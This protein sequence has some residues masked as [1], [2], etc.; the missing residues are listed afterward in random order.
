MR[1][2]LQL[3]DDLFVDLQRWAER[4]GLTFSE[5]V[6]LALRQSLA[7]PDKSHRRFRQKTVALGLPSFDVSCANAADARLEDEEIAHRARIHG[8]RLRYL[9]EPFRAEA[10]GAKQTVKTCKALQ[11][12]LG[13]LNDLHNLAATVGEALE[14]ASVERAR[15]LREL[16][17]RVDGALETEL[18][19][20]HEPGLLAMLQ[21]I[22]RD[23]VSMF[24]SLVNDWLAPGGRLDEL[25]GQIRSLGAH[26]RGREGVEIERKYLLFGL[27]PRCEE[28]APLT[29]EQGYLPGERLVE[30]VRRITDGGR[31]TTL[32]TVKLGAGVQRIEV[33]EECS[34][35]LFDALYAL[36]EG[37]RVRKHRF[38]VP[39]GSLL[40]EID[41]FLDRELFLAEVELPTADTEVSVPEWLLPYLVR[42]VTDEPAY[43]NAVLAR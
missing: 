34:P 14:D 33:E 10:D 36:T 18:A 13:D 9:L 8:K 38:R 35:E 16:A 22:Q 15:R 43:V 20:D 2:T 4:E 29:L 17:I 24:D 25:D 21:R 1:I 30:R 31:T 42:D 5:L 11:D 23:R 27:P 39:E 26:M 37:R 28:V 6:D 40:W 7:S 12:L 41:R 32:R 3:D 19:T